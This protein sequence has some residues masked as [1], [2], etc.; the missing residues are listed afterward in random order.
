MLDALAAAGITDRIV[1][2]GYRA[3]L[4][5]ETLADLQDVSFALQKEQRGTGDAVAAAASLIGQVGLALDFAHANGVVHGD[6][7]PAN[8]M[9]TSQ[10]AA[11]V[12]DF[13]LAH[14]VS[15]AVARLALAESWGMSPYMAP[16][17]E[18]G[19]LSRESDLYSLGVILYE[20]VTGELPFPGPN[21]LAQKREMHFSLLRLRLHAGAG[22][23]G[24]VTAPALAALLACA[25]MAAGARADELTE[26]DKE[27]I[28]SARNVSV[29]DMR[30][31][32]QQAGKLPDG[33]IAA[34]ADPRA[35]AASQQ[36][37]GKFVHELEP[38]LE[39]LEAMTTTYAQLPDLS[40]IDGEREELRRGLLDGE[41]RFEEEVRRFEDVRKARQAAELQELFSASRKGGGSQRLRDVIMVLYSSNNHDPD[42]VEKR[43][44]AVYPEGRNDAPPEIQDMLSAAT[45]NHAMKDMSQRL[46]S[47]LQNEAEAYEARR[48]V[49]ELERKKARERFGA[50]AAALVAAALGL[51]YWVRLRGRPGAA[52]GA[53]SLVGGSYRLE[54]EIGRGG[55]G[56]I[57]EATDVSLRRKVAVKQ[58]RPELKQNPKDLEAF[59]AE[60]RLVAALRHPHIVE[61]YAIVNEGADLYLVFELVAGQSLQTALERVGRLRLDSAL[62]LMGQVGSALDFAHAN[63]VIHRDLKPANIMLTPQGKALVMDFGLAHRVS[64]TVARLTGLQSSGTPPYMAP[65][66]ELGAASRESDLYSL[67]VMLYEALTGSQPFPGP[68]YL[69]Q[70]REMVFRL[71]T[72]A[73]P[74]LPRGLDDFMRRAL[75]V[76]PSARFHSASEF[77]REL[78][79]LS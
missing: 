65:E 58:L 76:E 61:I 20:A 57:F 69:A 72:Q 60:A 25:L 73:A 11:K 2:V 75:A 13:G 40:A 44:Q 27:R 37:C 35:L 31:M 54:R 74:E 47:S 33:A 53:G 77:L 18:L 62:V 67:A 30:N 55:M 36:A 4:V 24:R 12:M 56:V 64:E 10:G 8:I 29:E 38:L 23:L 70:K 34:G 50:A 46:R 79:A 15:L 51:W 16:E 52:A 32:L 21:F 68:N 42:H 59:L 71:P 5:E 9:L 78:G 19:T 1:V 14:H 7:K 17:Q 48:Q 26:D 28:R 39:R 3:A 45:F 22:G 43:L 49:F 66:Q 6:L 41:A 63:N